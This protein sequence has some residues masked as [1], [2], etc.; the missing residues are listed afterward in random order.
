MALYMHTHIR[1]SACLSVC[2]S[3]LPSFIYSFMQS[4]SQ[5]ACLG[6]RANGPGFR[7]VNCSVR[8]T[9]TTACGP[10][11]LWKAP[12]ALCS[13]WRRQ[14]CHPI[15]PASS[16]PS[17]H[18][19]VPQSPLQPPAR[20]PSHTRAQLGFVYVPVPVPVPV[21]VYQRRTVRRPRWPWPCITSRG[22]CTAMPLTPTAA[23]PKQCVGQSPLPSLSRTHRH[24]E[25]LTGTQAHRHTYKLTLTHTHTCHD[26]Q[27][28]RPTPSRPC[29]VTGSPA[30]RASAPVRASM[31]PHLCTN[32]CLCL[33]LC[34]SFFLSLSVCGQGAVVAQL[35]LAA[36]YAVG[37]RGSQFPVEMD[38]AESFRYGTHIHTRTHAC[39]HTHTQTCIHIHDRTC[40]NARTHAHVHH[41][42]THTPFPSPHLHVLSLSLYV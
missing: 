1:A 14:R 19:S 25:R 27:A 15:G 38:V 16:R 31:H 21:H 34:R 3:F 4:V 28:K 2:P 26:R 5:S 40:T 33:S 41:T 24:T 8:C 36:I 22:A 10:S 9:R 30:P 39:I 7:R 20:F 6:V 35:K 32:A 11:R 37:R 42:L 12:A 18:R 29:F 13:H 23:P 17:L